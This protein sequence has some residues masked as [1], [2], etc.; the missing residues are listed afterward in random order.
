MPLWYAGLILLLILLAVF[1]IFLIGTPKSTLP[2]AMVS[3]HYDQSLVT[4]TKEYSELTYRGLHVRVLK[5]NKNDPSN[6]ADDSAEL[7]LRTNSG[8]E[9][10]VAKKHETQYKDAFEVTVLDMHP[11]TE[12]AGTADLAGEVQLEIKDRDGFG[13]TPV[14]SS[15]PVAFAAPTHLMHWEVVDRTG[16]PLALSRRVRGNWSVSPL[17]EGAFVKDDYQT[18]AG[19]VRL[20]LEYRGKQGLS[21]HYVMYVSYPDK[22]QTQ[23]QTLI[24]QYS[25][26]ITEIYQSELLRVRIVPGP[27]ME[28]AR[29]TPN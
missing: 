18:S 3:A 26:Y 29:T 15:T 24:F 25:G 9:V 16:E 7:E 14:P 10:R 5:L 2:R 20:Q 8:T 11:G 6:D 12:A 4:I 28:G 21:D 17:K 27:L 22:P 19:A 1:F 13:S 23:S